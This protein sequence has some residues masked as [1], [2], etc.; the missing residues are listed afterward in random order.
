VKLCTAG[1]IKSFTEHHTSESV[2]FKVIANK[3]RLEFFLSFYLLCMLCIESHSLGFG[4]ID[5]TL[6]NALSLIST[7]TSDINDRWF[8]N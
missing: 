3:V 6:P 1:H 7:L 5:G 4:V 2:L 8:S